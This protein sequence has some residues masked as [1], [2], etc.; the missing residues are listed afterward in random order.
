MKPITECAC[1]LTF[2]S[3]VFAQPAAQGLVATPGGDYAAGYKAGAAEAVKDLEEGV[4]AF[5]IYGLR[6]SPEFLYRKTG[7]PCAVIAGCVVNQTLLGRAVGHDDRINEYILERGPPISS[8][9]RWEKDLFDLKGYFEK[10]TKTEKPHRLT[11]NGPAAV[12][13]D[14]ESAIWLVNTRTGLDG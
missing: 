1:L 11:L 4:A 2:S 12:S 9:K 3:V 14:G 8:F 10:R 6:E 5:Y 13:R 7:V